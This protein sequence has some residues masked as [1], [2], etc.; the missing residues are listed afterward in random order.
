MPEQCE[1]GRAHNPGRRVVRVRYVPTVE[2]PGD[3]EHEVALLLLAQ[4]QELLPGGRPLQP[5]PVP[6]L[7]F[8]LELCYERGVGVRHVSCTKD[9]INLRRAGRASEMS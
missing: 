5:E 8:G 1:H 6:G 9:H 2:P 7:L 3:R 4:G